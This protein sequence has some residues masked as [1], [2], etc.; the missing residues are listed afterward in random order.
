MTSLA[1]AYA[2][3][4]LRSVKRGFGAAGNQCLDTT[5]IVH[6]QVPKLVINAIEAAKVREIY[7]LYLK[8][9]TLLPVVQELAER[10][11][12]NKSWLTRK[13][14]SKGGRAFDKCS[15]YSLLTNPV[16]VGKIRHKENIYEGQHEAIIDQ[17][18]FDAVNALLKAHGR[19]SIEGKRLINR[20]DAL[21]KGLLYCPGCGNTMVHNVNKRK[22]KLYRYNVWPNGDQTRKAI[23]RHWFVACG[24]YRSGCSERDTLHRRR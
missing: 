16:Y 19:K 10:G 5:S 8:L 4:S 18:T 24:S 13:G 11:W 23:V 14:H 22:S 21:L 1:N 7:E 12:A 9:R 2:T 15:V 17:M 3:R 6:K 20:H